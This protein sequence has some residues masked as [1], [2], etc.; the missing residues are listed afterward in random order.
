VAAEVE[1]RDVPEMTRYEATVAGAAAGRAEYVIAADL[2]VFSHT[3]VEPAYEGH[4]VGS[5]LAKFSLDDARERGLAVLPLC[6]FFQ[7]WIRRHPEYRDLVFRPRPSR[8]A[9]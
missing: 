9:D 1:V 4:G 2:I 8:V 7:G 3:E 6:P 5:A